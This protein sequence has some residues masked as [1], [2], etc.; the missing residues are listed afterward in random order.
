MSA[1]ELVGA[2]A[3]VSAVVVAVLMTRT[4][5]LTGT[6]ATRVVVLVLF[7]VVRAWM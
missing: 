7:V 1:R 3:V 6:R 5:V 2:L 4:F